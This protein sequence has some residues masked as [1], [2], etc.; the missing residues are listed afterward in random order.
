M[1]PIFVPIPLPHDFLEE[2]SAPKPA[3]PT[4]DTFAKKPNPQAK[5]KERHPAKKALPPTKPAA[6]FQAIF[7]DSYPKKLQLPEW[8]P[9]TRQAEAL[10]ALIVFG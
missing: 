9:S 10:T 3:L 6:R 1:W 7:L 4:R 2:K 8:E 5:P